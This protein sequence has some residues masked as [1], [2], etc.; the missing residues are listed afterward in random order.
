MTGTDTVANYELALASVTYEDTLDDA[1]T[2][3]RVVTFVVTDG[4]APGDAA[5]VTVNPQVD[6]VTQL[7]ITTPSTIT[8]G[9]EFAVTVAAE[10]ANNLVVTNFSGSETLSLAA[11]PGSTLGG[12]LTVSATSGVAT[13]GG[14]TLDT[15]GSGY[16]L[17]ATS[18]T[19]TGTS[20]SF[21]VSPVPPAGAEFQ[22]NTFT[23][24]NQEHA[25]VATDAA[26]D[27]VV[28]WQSYGQ[29]GSGYGIYAQLY[30]ASGTEMGSEFQVNT[31]TTGN[32]LNPVVAMDSEGD[33]VVAWEGLYETGGG[34]YQ[35]YVQQYNAA[36]ARRGV[37]FQVDP[38]YGES[39][40][41][42]SIAMDSQG[43]FIIVWSTYDPGFLFNIHAQQ[44]NASGAA[45]GAEIT[46][47]RDIFRPC[48]R[49]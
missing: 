13:F 43:D 12:T 38:G 22:V 9:N 19:L 10:D 20:S 6:V 33:F 26:G 45:Y 36:G 18:G 16:Q 7:V 2:T 1:T 27:Y 28:V 15:A 32:Q 34:G 40:N 31:Y 5:S 39:H 42:P 37:E 49:R 29:D 17:G 4:I 44:Y 25:K 8:A 23:P 24:S 47:G 41:A 21:T 30:N 35:I 48:L 11:G 46:I 14:L 3:A